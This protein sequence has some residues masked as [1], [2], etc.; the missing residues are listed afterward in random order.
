MAF[1]NG[2]TPLELSK[3]IDVTFEE[4]KDN[5]SSEEAQRHLINIVMLAVLLVDKIRESCIKEGSDVSENYL[6]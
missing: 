6:E 4:Y 5:M 3:E 2:I 1:S